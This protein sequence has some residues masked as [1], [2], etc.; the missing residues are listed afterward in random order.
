MR[1][2]SCRVHAAPAQGCLAYGDHEPKERALAAIPG[3]PASH[4]IP[5]TGDPGPPP[6]PAPPI[7]RGCHIHV[8]GTTWMWH[9]RLMTW[10]GRCQ[11]DEGPR[12]RVHVPPHRSTKPSGVELQQHERGIH[13]GQLTGT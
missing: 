9:P 8:A 1:H 2:T 5:V 6:A 7:R 4:G 11:S 10:H 12:S 13:G 3:A